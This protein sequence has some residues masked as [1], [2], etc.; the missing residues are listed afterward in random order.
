VTPGY[1]SDTSYRAPTGHPRNTGLSARDV[2]REWMP[3]LEGAPV[4]ER[5]SRPA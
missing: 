5:S 2:I 1:L 4:G 3:L